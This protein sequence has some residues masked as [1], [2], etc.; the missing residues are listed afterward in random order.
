MIDHDSSADLALE[1]NDVV[2]VFSTA[3]ISV[4]HLQETRYVRIDGEVK[5]RRHLCRRSWRIAE[6]CRGECGRADS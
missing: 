1:P 6:G 3:D 5:T 4:Q 2:T